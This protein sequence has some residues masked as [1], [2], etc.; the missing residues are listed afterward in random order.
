MCDNSESPSRQK[1]VQK[2][3]MLVQ[4]KEKKNL[5]MYNAV[6]CDIDCSFTSTFSLTLNFKVQFASD[7]FFSP[8]LM[9]VPLL[10][11]NMDL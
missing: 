1:Q 5:N 3:L 9:G 11:N 7:F 4:Y 6:Y 2:T 10:G 8:A